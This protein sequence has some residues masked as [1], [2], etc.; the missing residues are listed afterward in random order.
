MRFDKLGPHRAALSKN[1]EDALKASDQHAKDAA[2][3]QADMFGVLTESHED[4]EKA[5][6]STPR[7]SEK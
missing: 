5:Y 6:A 2:M 7:W 1:L 4:V 3:G